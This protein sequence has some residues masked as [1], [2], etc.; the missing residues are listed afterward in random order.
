MEIVSNNKR[1]AWNQHNLTNLESPDSHTIMK[2]SSAHVYT[3]CRLRLCARMALSALFLPFSFNDFQS[4]SAGHE[5]TSNRAS[6]FVMFHG[7]FFY[8]VWPPFYFGTV[9][10]HRRHR[11][12]EKKNIVRC[13]FCSEKI[14]QPIA[15]MFGYLMFLMMLTSE[16]KARKKDFLFANKRVYA[17]RRMT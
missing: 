16:G 2:C 12:H 13:C 3:M 10:H 9:N 6:S 7:I 14:F 5:K 4:A 17:L 1:L 8:A 15:T 11:E